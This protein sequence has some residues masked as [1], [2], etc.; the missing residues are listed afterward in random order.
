MKKYIY[1]IGVVIFVSLIT[2]IVMQ[3]EK[4]KSITYDRDRLSANQS[5]L[6]TEIDTFRTKDGLNA[7]KV[8]ELTLTVSEFKKFR[9]GDIASIKSLNADVNRLQS[10]L[11]VNTQTYYIVKTNVKDSIVYK[12]S[13]IHKLK[14]VEYNNA[15]LDF[16]G[17][18]N[19]YGV[20]D[21]KIQ[22]RDSLV[23]VEYIVPKRFLGFLW[24]YGCKEKRREII[25]KNP[26]TKILNVEFVT[27]K[28]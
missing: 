5:E 9:A 20:F 26:Y 1:I 14:C 4:I 6:M 24:K 2:T 28:K 7:A 11:K 3:S 27:I 17:C 15:W 22:S 13:I 16:N 12:D 23:C 25:S 21:G 18:I 8:K 19:E 10:L